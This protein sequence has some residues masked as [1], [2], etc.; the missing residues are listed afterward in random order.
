MHQKLT[1]K[2]LDDTHLVLIKSLLEDAGLPHSDVTD[3]QR[4]HFW[5]ISEENGSLAGVVGLEHFQK[6]A[7]LRSLC[8]SEEMRGRGVGG[9][10]V[11]VIEEFARQSGIRKLYLLTE[12]AEGFFRERGFRVIDRLLAPHTIQN[13]TEFSSLCP[14]SAICMSKAVGTQG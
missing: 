1:I 6:S 5:G 4:I 9:Q 13:T 2:Q 11:A 12:T 14:D 3:L 7:L 8:V 10:L